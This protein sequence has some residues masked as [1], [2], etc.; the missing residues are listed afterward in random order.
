M[1]IKLVSHAEMCDTS[2]IRRFLLAI[3][4][5]DYIPYDD[6]RK[7]VSRVCGEMDLSCLL[8]TKRK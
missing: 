7:K 8:V 2:K 5:L 4:R 6:S 3:I 1:Y